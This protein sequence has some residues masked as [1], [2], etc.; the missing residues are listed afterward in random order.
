MKRKYIFLVSILICVSI[1][2]FWITKILAQEDT[3]TTFP[4]SEA[5]IAA[6]TRS[7]KEITSENLVGVGDEL[8]RSGESYIIVR[9]KNLGGM[10]NTP[11]NV[12]IGL[13]GWIVAYYSR[14]EP[15]SEIIMLTATRTLPSKAEIIGTTLQKAI[16]KVCSQMNVSCSQPIKYYDFEFPEANKM[17]L[18]GEAVNY[19]SNSQNKEFFA[20]IPGTIYEA[21]YTLKGGL[22]TSGWCTGVRSVPVS[23]KVDNIDILKGDIGFP[24]TT[25][26]GKFDTS[27]YFQPNIAH[28]V[29][30]SVNSCGYA[31]GGFAFVYKY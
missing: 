21:S 18:V 17:T 27:I 26:V 15:V 12:Y 11:V 30:L 13:D 9:V 4:V 5:G 31:L 23:L 29:A 22:Y 14:G 28:D 1:I 25:F 16:E 8:V 7:D 2:P 10:D 24:T 20:T 6:Y 3:S 19:D